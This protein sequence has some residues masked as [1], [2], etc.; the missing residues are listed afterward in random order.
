MAPE[1]NV[2]AIAD[3]TAGP[4][5]FNTKA[6]MYHNAFKTLHRVAKSFQ[7]KQAE[8][9]VQTASMRSPLWLMAWVMFFPNKTFPHIPTHTSKTRPQPRRKPI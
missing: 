9:V 6:K 7:P 1:G 5:P 2:N 3:A 8:T 4:A